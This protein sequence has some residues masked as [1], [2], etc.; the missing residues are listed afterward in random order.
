MFSK[1]IPIKYIFVDFF[2]TVCFRHIHSHQVY[3]QWAKVLRKKFPEIANYYSAEQIVTMRNEIICGLEMEY[4]EPPYQKVMGTLYKRFALMLGKAV[5]EDSF[6]S[7]NKDIDIAV[8]LGCQYPNRVVINYLQKSKESGKKIYIVSDFY[9]P[10]DSYQFF[11]KNM[12][13]ESL[14]DGIFVSETH[15]KTKRKGSLYK[16]IIDNLGVN[17]KECLMIGDSR[18]SDYKMAKF[19]GF[20]AKWYFPFRHKVCTNFSK[21]LS[22]D[23]GNSIIKKKA[24][25]LYN[26]TLYEEYAVILFYFVSQLYKR[27]VHDKVNKL[28]FLSRGGFFLKVLFDEYQKTIIP[29]NV[30]I[31]SYYCYNSRKVC[32]AAES[33]EDKRNAL[34]NYLLPF[35]DNNRLYIVDEGWY[36]HSQQIIAKVTHFDTYGYYIGTRAKEHM[37]LKNTCE[38]SGLLFDVSESGKRTPFY[39]IF[40]TNCSTYEQMLTARHGSVDD[41]IKEGSKV[42]PLLKENEKE[43][44]LYDKYIV[45]WQDAMLLDFKGIVAWQVDKDVKLSTLAKIVLKTSFFA[46]KRRIE[47]L[48]FLDKSRYD[49]CSDGQQNTD[50]TI[51]DVRISIYELIVHPDRY[52]GM[53]SKLQRKLVGRPLLMVVYYPIAYCFYWYVR[54]CEKI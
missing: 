12:K 42:K 18:H 47:Y 1:N 26:N 13:I 40:C 34:E 17:P 5:S 11:L 36:N 37:N 7:I 9:L 46:S 15:N 25:Y 54:I 19:A 38:R 24:R 20:N 16:Y 39:G 8:E 33:D 41:Y 52:V 48:N 44:V 32:F 43:L 6:I 21:Q 27:V 51:K 45:G 29:N 14:F 31:G 50:K 28:S 23:Y 4:E 53:F 35:C 2:D 22:L 3:L 10:I 49:N 30:S